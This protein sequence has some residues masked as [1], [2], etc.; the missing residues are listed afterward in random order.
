MLVLFDID[1]TLVDDP[2][3]VRAG[4]ATLHAYVE[5][6]RSVDAFL[7][8]W[9]SSLDRHYDRYLRGE[10]DFLGQRR[11]RVIEVLGTQMDD[12]TADELFGIYLGAYESALQLYSDTLDCLDA[13]GG[14]VLGIVSNGQDVQQRC[15]LQA[16]GILGRFEVFAISGEVG[17]SKPDP[18]IFLEACS[19]AGMAPES[20]VYVGDRYETDALGARNAGLSGVWLDRAGQRSGRNVAPIVSSLT[21]LAGFIE[22]QAPDYQRY[23]AERLRLDW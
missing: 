3:A 19:R 20:A 18:A 8:E 6:D 7:T 14:H 17:S 2:A 13:L 12:A 5:T 4:V 21:E 15:K 9:E 11:A 16:T 10:V 1:G 22:A 23:G